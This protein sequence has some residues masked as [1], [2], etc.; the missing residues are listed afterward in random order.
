[1]LGMT[2]CLH[3]P[4]LNWQLYP[5]EDGKQNLVK[6]GQVF[7]ELSNSF[8]AP[9]PILWCCPITL[10]SLDWAFA[11]P[12]TLNCT[13]SVSWWHHFSICIVF[14]RLGPSAH[15]HLK[16]CSV[17]V[18]C[19]HTWNVEK[20]K[21]KEGRTITLK[22]FGKDDGL[23]IAALLPALVLADEAEAARAVA[24]AL[25]DLCLIS[26]QIGKL[27]VTQGRG[28]VLHRG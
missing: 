2:L 11:V 28:R 22:F 25:G 16:C 12:I 21:L 18:F 20:A 27:A 17:L 6:W 4:R 15:L 7:Q 24:E 26:F 23:N 5:E 14:E 10:F 9:Y 13:S 1:M 8:C 3:S 19:G